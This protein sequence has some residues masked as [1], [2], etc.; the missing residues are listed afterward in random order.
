[1]TDNETA[2]RDLF[3]QLCTAWADGDAEAFAALYADDATSISPMAFASGRDA[4]R[5][6]MAGAFAGPF[7]GTRLHDEFHSVRFPSPTTAL[8]TVRS[9]ALRPGEEPA[10]ASGWLHATW[11]LGTDGDGWKVHAFH[12]CPEA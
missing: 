7:K 1:M 12:G 2:V 3:D 6:R 5:D 8:V 4:V 11:V 9:V 10:S